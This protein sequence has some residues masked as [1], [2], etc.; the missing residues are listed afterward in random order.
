MRPVGRLRFAR[1]RFVIP[2]PN[3]P[4]HARIVSYLTVMSTLM[5]ES[6]ETADT[7]QFLQADKAFDAVMSDAAGNSYLTSIL[8][9]LQT[10]SRRF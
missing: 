4:N 7:N 6:R 9:P 8:G 10:H 5:L 3:F 2:V 1:I